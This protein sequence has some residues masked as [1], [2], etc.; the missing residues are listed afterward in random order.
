M[1]TN[2]QRSA[3]GTPLAA[4]LMA[5]AVKLIVCAHSRLPSTQWLQFLNLDGL[6][7]ELATVMYIAEATCG[8]QLSIAL[9]LCKSGG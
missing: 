9:Q 4:F 8:F 5:F 3:H 7:L 1:L 2:G 6:A